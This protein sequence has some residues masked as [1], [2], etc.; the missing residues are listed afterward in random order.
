MQPMQRALQRILSSPFSFSCA[1]LEGQ[2]I[3]FIFFSCVCNTQE[4]K[5]IIFKKIGGCYVDHRKKNPRREHRESTYESKY[6]ILIHSNHQ[7]V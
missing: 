1:L 6:F 3:F 4:K 5:Q 7:E 2:S